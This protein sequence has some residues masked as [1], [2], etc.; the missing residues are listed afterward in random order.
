MQWGVFA[1][2]SDVIYSHSQSKTPVVAKRDT[3]TTKSQNN[4][5]GSNENQM[6]NFYIEKILKVHLILPL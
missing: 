2:G 3:A 6:L 5:T 1:W 4:N